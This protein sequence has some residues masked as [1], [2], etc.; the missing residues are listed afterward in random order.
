MS[1]EEQT[2]IR[3]LLMVKPFAPMELYI[4]R[5]FALEYFGPPSHSTLEEPSTI[6][7]TFQGDL[8]DYQKK[9]VSTYI[10]ETN[11]PNTDSGLLEIPCGRGKC[12]AKNTKIRMYDIGDKITFKY[13]QVD[14]MLSHPKFVYEILKLLLE[15]K[16]NIK[17]I[18]NDHFFYCDKRANF[19]VVKAFYTHSNGSILFNSKYDVIFPHDK[20]DKETKMKYIRRLSRLKDLILNSNEKLVF[21]YSSQSS[22]KSGNFTIDERVIIKNVYFYYNI[23]I[24][25]S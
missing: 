14:W 6:N 11:N 24:F 22:L 3:N 13:V 4:P 8:R 21:I 2:K 7:L 9:I 10:K 19:K 18:V 17:E 20:N 15:N 1:V 23:I 16:I 5:Y 12:F 25:I